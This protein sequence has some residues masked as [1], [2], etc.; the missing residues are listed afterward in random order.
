MREILFRG[1]TDKGEWVQGAYYHQAE[2]YGEQCSFHYIIESCD[3]LED[4]MMW[5]LRVIPETIG[6]YTGLTDKNGKK[7]FEGDIVIF[8]FSACVVKY[9]FANGRYMFY[10]RGIYLKNGFNVDT[11]KTKEVVG[12]ITDNPELLKG[13]AE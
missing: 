4:N 3:E 12:N 13:G 1:K 5:A 6:Q 9:D 10:D 2:F 11:M 7:I 8:G